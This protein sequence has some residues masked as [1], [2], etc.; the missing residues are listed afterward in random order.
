MHTGE[1]PFV[2]A[3]CGASFTLRGSLRTHQRTHLGGESAII[4]LLLTLVHRFVFV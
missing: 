1:K 4:L 3:H 2:C